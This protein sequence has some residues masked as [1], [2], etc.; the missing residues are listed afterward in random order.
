MKLFTKVSK[1][2]GVLNYNVFMNN[3]YIAEIVSCENNQSL[4]K[5]NYRDISE[6]DSEWV[7][8]KDTFGKDIIYKDMDTAKCDAERILLL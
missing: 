6:P 4:Y 5:L 2:T 1:M 8:M 3:N 7:T